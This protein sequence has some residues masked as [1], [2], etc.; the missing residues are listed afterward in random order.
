MTLY[1]RR[2]V[3]PEGDTQ[4]IQ[5]RLTIGQLVDLNGRPL[6]LPLPTERMIVYRVGRITTETPRGEEITSYH[7][8]LMRVDELR[9]M[10]GGLP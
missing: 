2:L 9:E 8:E 7:L 6:P 4:E 3:Y 10:M 1:S 5:H